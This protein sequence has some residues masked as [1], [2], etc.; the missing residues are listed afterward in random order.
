LI[1]NVLAAAVATLP[2]RLVDK[3]RPNPGVFQTILLLL[4]W[5]KFQ[6]E[7]GALQL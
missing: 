2:P 7:C 4:P 5:T 3:F 1:P 6:S